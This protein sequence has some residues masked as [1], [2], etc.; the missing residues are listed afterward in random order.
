M[1]LPNQKNFY[2]EKRYFQGKDN[3]GDLHPE[4]APREPL[5]RAQIVFGIFFLIVLA[6][7]FLLNVRSGSVPLPPGAAPAPPPPSKTLPA[8]K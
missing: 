8:N 6:V 4:P 2:D 1:E 5:P 7:L 3:P